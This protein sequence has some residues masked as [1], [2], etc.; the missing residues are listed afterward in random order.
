MRTSTRCGL[1]VLLSLPAFVSREAQADSPLTS[2]DFHGAYANVREVSLAKRTKRATGDVLRLLLDE[3]APFAHKAA[4]INALGY[5][6][7]NAPL[8]L[9]GLATKRGQPTS[10]LRS[11]QLTGHELFCLGYLRAMDDYLKLSALAPRRRG[12][13]GMRPKALLAAAAKKAPESFTVHLVLAL[14]RAQ[15]AMRSS[16]CQ[17]YT[18]VEKVLQGFVLTRRDFSPAALRVVMRYID[19][20]KKDCKRFKPKRD[21]ELDQIY[22]IT[23]YQRWIVTGT[24]G[25]V[26]FW[27]AASGKVHRTDKAFISSV[28]LVHGGR[29]WVGAH[30]QLSAYS[31]DQ[32]KVYL[33]VKGARGIYPFLTPQGALMAR[34]GRRL[35]RYDAKR[36][37]FTK[38]GKLPKRAPYARLVRKN[39]DVWEID[40]LKALIHR[41]AN[42]QVERIARRSSRYP[43]GDP[44]RFYTDDR[45]TLWV[46]DFDNGFYHYDPALKRFVADP[47][48]NAQASAMAIDVQRGRRWFL[49]YRQGLHL[50]SKD[51]PPRF[52]SLQKLKYMRALYLDPQSG[53][54]WV[55]GW[56]QLL[57]LE[58]RAHVWVQRAYRVVQP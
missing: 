46:A 19:L 44:R 13:L 2:A 58:Y 9:E 39:G 16:F 15:D 24:Q 53:D 35:Y 25:G 14:V 6:Q 57:R 27:E 10:K 11:S 26:V 32:P 5:G 52:F 47:V 28:L 43:G 30:H 42:G 21:P 49:H 56:G 33:K 51:R 4:V 54:V 45:G 17:V 41:K 3:Q 31:G 36:D 38:A 1:I 55:G 50:L 37:R 23:R 12:V 8:F 22:S 20:Y 40:F 29:L 18:L 34:R 48:V 7:R